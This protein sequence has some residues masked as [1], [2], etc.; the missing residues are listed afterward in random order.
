LASSL[1][2]IGQIVKVTF[3][4]IEVK[5]RISAYF[6][7][8]GLF[9]LITATL[10]NSAY[11]K[12]ESWLSGIIEWLPNPASHIDYTP[13]LENNK[14]AHNSQWNS[15]EW[16]AEDWIRQRASALDTI[17][18]L[19]DSHILHDQYIEEGIAVLEVGSSFYRLSGYDKRRITALIDSV[20]GITENTVLGMYVIN[21]ASSGKQI[22]AYT[23]DGLQMQ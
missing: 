15:E 19:Y 4:L 6:F 7:A 12:S 9:T 11:A 23:S 8:I 16:G 14:Q 5:M 22:G 3:N 20:Y 2:L 10:P 21:D 1:V 13:Y 17:Q 18:R